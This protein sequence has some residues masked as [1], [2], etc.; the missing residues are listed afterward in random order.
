VELYFHLPNVPLWC[1]AQ[2]IKLITAKT[3]LSPFLEV[4]N[5]VLFQTTLLLCNVSMLHQEKYSNFSF[6]ATRKDCE[7]SKQHISELLFCG[8]FE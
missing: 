1:G 2:F 3:L 4:G 8:S 7:A 6:G 5:T